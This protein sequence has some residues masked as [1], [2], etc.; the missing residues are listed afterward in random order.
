MAGNPNIVGVTAIYGYV[1]G[2]AV[3]V[4]ATA[5]VSNAAASGLVYKVNALYVGN[6]DT[7]ASY[8]ITA[9]VVKGSTPYR[10]LYQISIPAGAGLDVLSKAIY[11]QEGDSIQL[12]A[13][14][15]SKLEAVCSYETIAG[16]P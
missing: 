12:T 11:L 3:P 10:M 4:S 15:V 14:T 7:A 2:L 8:K 6:I 13:D 5:I 9:S 16:P 1:A